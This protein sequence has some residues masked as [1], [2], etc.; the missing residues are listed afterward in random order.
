MW[1]FAWSSAGLHIPI[2]ISPSLRLTFEPPN[3]FRR[4]EVGRLMNE[5]TDLPA[6]D[7]CASKRQRDKVQRI[8]IA[9]FLPIATLPHSIN[10]LQIYYFFLNCANLFA[11]IRF[12]VYLCTPFHGKYINNF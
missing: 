7:T 6:L 1:L 9:I 5:N 10:R 4:D 12:F 3:A 2:E 11:Y 8:R